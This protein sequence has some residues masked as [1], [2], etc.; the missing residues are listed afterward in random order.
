MR[1][2]YGRWVVRRRWVAVTLLALLTLLAVLGIGRRLQQG[3]P[4]D[5]T[6]Q[7]IF[8]DQG[9]MLD[10]LREIEQQFGRS[11]NDLLLVLS[12]PAL[13][14][15]AGEAALRALHAAMADDADVVQVDSLLTAPLVRSDDSGLIIGPALEGRS[16]A[17]ALPLAE[18]EP[19]LRGLLVSADG[20]TTMIRARIDGRLLTIAELAPAVW[21][22]K[23][24]AEATPMPAGLALTVTGVPYVRAEVVSMMVT[25]EMRF[26]PIVAVLFAVTICLLFRRIQLGLGPLV[27]VLGAIV[28][29]MG[30]LLVGGATF[31]ILSVL[32]PVLVLIIGVAD[33]IHLTGRYQEE[34][35]EDGDREAAMGRTM[36]HMT[37][38]CFLTTFTTATSFAS[39]L[40]ADTKV[41]RDF[42]AHSAVAVMIAW[43]GVMLILPTWLAFVPRARVGRPLTA[44]AGMEQRLFSGLDRLVAAHAR[45]VVVVSALLAVAAAGLGSQVQANSRL[46]EMYAPAHSTYAAIHHIERTLSGVVPLFVHIEVE[47]GDLL[48]PERLARMEA[49]EAALDEFS[50]VRWSSSLSGQVRRIHQS[51]TGE[52]ALPDSRAAVVQEL[53]LAELSGELSLDELVSEDHRQA[54]IIARC[55]DDGG[56]EMMALHTAMQ[57]RA[58]ALF[59]DARV[60]VTGDGLIAAIG[61]GGLI[62]DLLSSVGLVFAVILV[63]MVW[64]LRDVRLALLSLLPNLL[65]LVFTLATLSVMGA[66][67]Q[68]SN[69]VSFTVAIGLAVDDTIHFLARYRQELL[70]GQ[71]KREAI[72]RAYLG[73]GHAIVLTSV[74]L[75][76]GFAV[77]STS[78]LTTTRHFGVLSSVTMIAAVLADL[79]LLP[80]LLHLAPAPR[81]AL[82]A[83][84][85]T[86]Q[87]A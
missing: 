38:A 25:D 13:P 67:L 39:L 52:D 36:R 61:I 34:L 8:I 86:S 9:P 35:A 29:A 14:S 22:L 28:W 83:S 63:M 62:D 27:A 79:L 59:P 73:A 58:E 72:R 50:I 26:V 32:I 41:I 56:Q 64:L 42:G 60:D 17:Q 5:F 57:A 3:L 10:R 76:A 74:L 49:L 2:R 68:T 15:P 81:W 23:A 46:L 65:P 1:E 12:G 47:E 82:P 48:E 24:T 21:R 80:A 19:A 71:G 54:R 43:V 31:N 40:I 20:L 33:G 87:K 53:L 6:P 7:A 55:A 77:L 85:T 37:T 70:S 78:E 11:D 84:L 51:L 30:A 18:E 75:V 66:D 69:I 45:W 16:L 44:R 4:V